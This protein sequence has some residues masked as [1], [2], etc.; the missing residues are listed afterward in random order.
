MPYEYYHNVYKKFND[1]GEYN[2]SYPHKLNFPDRGNLWFDDFAR[3]YESIEGKDKIIDDSDYRLD[4]NNVIVGCE[5]LRPGEF[6]RY[7][8]DTYQKGRQYL[9]ELKD[10][11]IEKYITLLNRKLNYYSN[12][13]FDTFIRGELGLDGYIGLKYKNE[14]IIFD[15]LYNVNKSGVRSLLIKPEALYGL[16]SDRLSLIRYPKTVLITEKEK[17][18]RIKRHY[19]TDSNSFENN[20]NKIINGPNLSTSTFEKEIDKLSTKMLIKKL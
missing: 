4:I 7:A 9:N 14:Y 20:L 8:R 12:S 1:R 3:E 19:H 13:G 17:D 5:L 2:S 10:V 15:Q 18:D 16:P 11:N 6:D